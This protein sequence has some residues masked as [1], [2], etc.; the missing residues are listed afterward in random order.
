MDD[1]EPI[2][3]SFL[4]TLTELQ[5]NYQLKTD[6]NFVN[7][8]KMMSTTINDLMVSITGRFESFDLS[9][10]DM[11]NNISAER[12]RTVEQVIRS[13]HTSIGGILCA[14]SVKMN[15]W[16]KLFPRNEVGGPI[17]RSD[18]I[19][20]EMRQGIDKIQLIEDHAPQMPELT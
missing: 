5:R 6:M 13:Y 19:M 2:I 14:L 3:S 7:T 17:K 1:I 10:K 12:F 11:W 18:F 8:S 9:T 20:S 4:D 16:H 15:T